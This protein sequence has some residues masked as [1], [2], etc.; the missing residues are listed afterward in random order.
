M[1][2]TA[3]AMSMAVVAMC[4]LP[5]SPLPAGAG[6]ADC[7]AAV[8]TGAT[9]PGLVPV[10]VFSVELPH[11]ARRSAEASPAAERRTMRRWITEFPFTGRT[12][13]SLSTQGN[14]RP[15]SDRCHMA[16]P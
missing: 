11:A 14:S 1:P 2:P 4:P 12:T 5:E 15:L 9:L 6:A 7:E 8:A 16:K 3:L 13:Y 10:E